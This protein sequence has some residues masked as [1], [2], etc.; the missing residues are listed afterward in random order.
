[1]IAARAVGLDAGP[2]SGFDNAKLDE[3]FLQRHDLACS[4]FIRNLGY[5]N[6]QLFPR[7]PRWDFDEV[8]R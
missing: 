2:M 8:A 5:G 3:V 6:V 7:S 1:M 4:N